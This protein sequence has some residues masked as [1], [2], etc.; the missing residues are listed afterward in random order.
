MMYNSDD[1]HSFFL[2][3]LAINVKAVSWQLGEEG[4]TVGS[5]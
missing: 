3:D 5:E 4:V 1:E 2:K